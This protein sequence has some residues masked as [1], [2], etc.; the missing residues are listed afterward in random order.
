MISGI[1]PATFLL[2]RQNYLAV[3]G[4]QRG[5]AW[6]YEVKLPAG[7]NAALLG[8]SPGQGKSVTQWKKLGI[9]LR[10]EPISLSPQKTAWLVK[11]DDGLERSFLVYN[12]F[13]TLMHWNRSYY[14]AISIG[15]MA[16]AIGDK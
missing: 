6:G 10:E 8:T 2:P 4:W 1:T 5:G 16:D 3:E 11:P 7:F 15:K 13:R 12:N 9:T 14:F